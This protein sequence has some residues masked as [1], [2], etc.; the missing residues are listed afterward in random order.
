[1]IKPYSKNTVYVFLP[2]LF[3]ETLIILFPLEA[4][5]NIP[6]VLS[7][8]ITSFLNFPVIK[9]QSISDNVMLLSLVILDFTAASFVPSVL[10]MF[11][12]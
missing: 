4:S 10:K 7:F 3:V 1:M 6:S 5:V 11:A 9:Q 2:F 8:Y 12:I